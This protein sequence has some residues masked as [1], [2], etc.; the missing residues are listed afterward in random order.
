M[1]APPIAADVQPAINYPRLLRA[2]AAV[3]GHRWSDE[4]GAIAWTQRAW[5]EDCSWPYAYAKNRELSM[6]IAEQRLERLRCYLR[7]MN[8]ATVANLWRYGL[9]ATKQGRVGNYGQR[10][11]NLYYDRSF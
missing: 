8:I 2:I 10:V 1:H 5:V 11:A 4:G 9:T 3:E 7:T 6:K